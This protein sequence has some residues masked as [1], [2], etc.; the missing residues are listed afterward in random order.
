MEPEIKFRIIV[1]SPPPGIV[2]GLQEGKGS[3]YKT[4]Q[5]QQSGEGDLEFAFTAKLKISKTYSIDFSG[6]FVQGVS[7]NR[8]V[9]IDIGT[10]AGQT[11]TP[12]SRRL[13]IP[14]TG[15]TPAIISKLSGDDHLILETKVPGTSVNGEPN[16]A[17][18]K[19]F[20]GWHLATV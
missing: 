2:Y 11:N 19:P 20:A 9:Y 4:I 14:L 17:T 7:G 6:A 16:C 5:K 13:K 15:I 12:W 18:V 8:F 10:Y 3:N 1:T